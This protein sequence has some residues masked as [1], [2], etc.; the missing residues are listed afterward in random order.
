MSLRAVRFSV[1]TIIIIFF[2][3]LIYEKSYDYFTNSVGHDQ[4]P[5]FVASDTGLCCLPMSL[6]LNARH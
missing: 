1:F 2:I 6:L 3:I 4:T 5:R